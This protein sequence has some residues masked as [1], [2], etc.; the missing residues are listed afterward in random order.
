MLVPTDIEELRSPSL[1]LWRSWE[2][3]YALES[4][5]ARWMNS[6]GYRFE[7][8]YDD[9]GTLR[10]TLRFGALPPEWALLMGEA[11]HGMRASLDHLVYALSAL[12]QGRALDEDEAR[13]TEFPIFGREPLSEQT[14]RRKIGLIGPALQETIRKVQPSERGSDYRRTMLWLLHDLDNR[15]K[16]RSIE[17]QLMSMSSVFP[18]FAVVDVAHVVLPNGPLHDGVEVFVGTPADPAARHSLVASMV[19]V[20]PFDLPLADGSVGGVG[21]V[22]VLRDLHRWVR[23][24]HH[25]LVGQAGYMVPFPESN[26]PQE[27]HE[28]DQAAFD[29]VWQAQM[30]P[31]D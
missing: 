14:Q 17:P 11:V 10:F 31:A 1:L 19:V 9:D 7:R 24:L 3:I 20:F 15:I 23:I 16:H 21:V 6:G 13:W 5:I 30:P 4:H 26:A 18:A 25:E 29:E 2:Q 28:Q 12:E 27:A 22:R 8:Q